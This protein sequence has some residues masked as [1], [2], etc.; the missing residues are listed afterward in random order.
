MPSQYTIEAQ[1][2]ERK[3]LTLANHQD[4]EEA[5]RGFIAAPPY[6]K[7]MN[8]KGDVVWNMDK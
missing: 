1:Q 3:I 6:R 5:K 8:D 2:Q 7:I 4:F